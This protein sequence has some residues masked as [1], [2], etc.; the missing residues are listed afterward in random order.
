MTA[1]V[2]RSSYTDV[3][4]TIDDIR[5]TLAGQERIVL[6]AGVKPD[7]KV[8]A[9]LENMAKAWLVRWRADDYAERLTS[10]PVIPLIIAAVG[11]EIVLRFGAD[12]F[13][14]TE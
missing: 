5:E 10:P 9:E 13:L 1:I 2:W 12:R 4:M 11:N 14:R 8:P 7:A 6:R 3:R